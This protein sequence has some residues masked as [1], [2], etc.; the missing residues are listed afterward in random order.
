MAILF[1]RIPA[2][3]LGPGRKFTHHGLIHGFVPVYIGDLGAEGPMIAVANGWPEWLEGVGRFLWVASAWLGE[4][5]VP[6]FECPGW[7]V[8]ILG[9]L[10]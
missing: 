7:R 2:S 9:R 8:Q 4:L 3:D 5:L 1:G 6:G 10:K